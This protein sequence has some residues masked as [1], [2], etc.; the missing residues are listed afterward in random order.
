MPCKALQRG[1]QS[2]IVVEGLPE[3]DAYVQDNLFRRHT[4]CV[5]MGQS[6]GKERVHNRRDVIVGRR[7]LHGAGRA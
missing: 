6:L 3:A 5:K 2:Q 1:E 7:L 4:G